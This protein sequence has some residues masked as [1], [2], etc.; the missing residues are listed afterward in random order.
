M[1]LDTVFIPIGW[2]ESKV[3]SF[4]GCSQRG[5]STLSSFLAVSWTLLPK[6]GTVMVEGL[7]GQAELK[8]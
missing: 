5:L 3:P 4:S 2:Q 1:W 8:K 6:G 7:S